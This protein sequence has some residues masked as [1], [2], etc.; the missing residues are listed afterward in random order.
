VMSYTYMD[1]GIASTLLF[2][3]PV[4]VAVIM[5][6]VYKERISKV[7]IACIAVVLIGISMLG[8]GE[9][10]ASLS[11]VGVM[12][13]M[14]SSLSYAIYIVGINKSSLDKVPTLTVTF[15]VLVFGAAV[16]AARL[17]LPSVPLTMPS[18]DG[19]QWLLWGCVAGLAILPTAVSFLCTTGAVQYIGS[20]PT[21]ILGALE[22][23]TAVVIGI[24]VFGESLSML[25]VVGIIL[26]ISAVSV[27]VGGSATVGRLGVQLLR[28]RRMF[29]P[30]RRRK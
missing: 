23:V 30:L 9:E 25:D 4:M 27:I 13:V 11:L 20:T 29:P 26:I 1:A 15:W 18:G 24:F 8:R 21:A 17:M 16:F 3:Y 10:G 7:T 2:V 22:P 6:G 14:V 12:I 19:N 5:A 28:I